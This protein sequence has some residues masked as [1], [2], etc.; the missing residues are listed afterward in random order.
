MMAVRHDGA[1]CLKLLAELDGKARSSQ[2]WEVIPAEAN[3]R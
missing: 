3:E 2:E 1:K